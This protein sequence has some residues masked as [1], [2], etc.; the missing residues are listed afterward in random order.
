VDEYQTALEELDEELASIPTEPELPQTALQLL[1]VTQEED[2]WQSYLSYLID[3]NASHGLD[4]QFLVAFL[5]CLAEHGA[6][7]FSSTLATDIAQDLVSVDSEYSTTNRNR[8]DIVVQYGTTWFLCIELKVNSEEHRNERGWQTVRYANDSDVVS[9]SVD[10]FEDGAYVFI[11]PVDSSPS[12][13]EEFVDVSWETVA[14]CVRDFL[15]ENATSVPTQ[16]AV[17]LD[18]LSTTIQDQVKMNEIDSAVRK[19]KELYFEYREAI[20]AV[21][22]SV[23]PFVK[24]VL[25]EGW[26]DAFLGEHQPESKESHEWQVE[27]VGKGWG[28]VLPSQWKELENE[29]RLDLHFE[30]KPTYDDFTQGQLRFI[31]E[32]EEPDSSTMDPQEGDRY[33]A[34]RSDILSLLDE[35]LNA[36]SISADEVG[37]DPK[38]TRKKLYRAVY[39]Y[40]PGDEEGYYSSLSTAADEHT[41]LVELIN[42]LVGSVDYSQYPLEIE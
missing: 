12:K 32:L 17:Q 13:S 15:G 33:Y 5:D 37:V 9:P 39:Q 1:S 10:E 18:E 42:E 14:D 28:Q 22:Q 2:A 23:E 27:A 4:Q 19:K 8:P 35:N 7:T 24:D 3:P 20:N 25:Q 40:A 21:E 29:L 30:H 11:A 6:V 34:F 16:T 38:R 31:L 36:Q 26:G 41:W